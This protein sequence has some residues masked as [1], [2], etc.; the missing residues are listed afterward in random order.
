[1]FENRACDSDGSP[2]SPI[3]GQPGFLPGC[4]LLRLTLRG[5]AFA[6]QRNIVREK[7]FDMGPQVPL[8]RN[9]RARVEL[10]ATRY[11]EQG[12]IARC[13]W[14]VLYVLMR[15]FQNR[16]TGACFPSYEAIA[17]AANVSEVSVWRAL[18]ELEACGLLRWVNRLIK[19]KVW[20]ERL[21]RTCWRVRYTSNAYT[22]TDPA[23]MANPMAP[24]IRPIVG[25]V[26]KPKPLTEEEI[27]SLV[28]I[29]ALKLE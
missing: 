12:R 2:T 6:T 29:A 23:T 21:Q 25:R 24:T 10:I 28:R 9:A 15:T 4:V 20:S 13:T 19:E 3:L 7:T 17:G 1:M 22:I 14:K 18:V 27:A 26:P 8:D 11:E 5:Y 16:L